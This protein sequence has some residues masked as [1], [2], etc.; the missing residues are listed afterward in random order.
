VIAAVVNILSRIALNFIM[1]YEI[2]IVVAYVC[3]MTSAYVL[4][5]LF[6]FAPS[7]SITAATLEAVPRMANGAGSAS[8]TAGWR[9]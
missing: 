1:S 5:K 4:N 7:V 3:G 6:V 8:S 9:R 2:A